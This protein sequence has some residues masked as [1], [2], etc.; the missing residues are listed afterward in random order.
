MSSPLPKVS[1]VLHVFD[2]IMIKKKKNV[3]R[4]CDFNPEKLWFIVLHRVNKYLNY[5]KLNEA[6]LPFTKRTKN[7]KTKTEHLISQCILD[8]YILKKTY[9][10]NIS[11]PLPYILCSELF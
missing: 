4:D 8:I 1:I 9:I 3:L 10:L 2:K 11:L 7:I 6:L 5:Q